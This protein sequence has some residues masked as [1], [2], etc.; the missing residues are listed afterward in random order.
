MAHENE[1]RT[2]QMA[3][4]LRFWLEHGHGRRFW[5][6]SAEEAGV[7]D[8]SQAQIQDATSLVRFIRGRL[9]RRAGV[10]LQQSSQSDG[11]R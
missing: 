5:R 2:E 4:V 3:F 1:P 6:G 8:P 10:L 9:F 7:D 11:Q